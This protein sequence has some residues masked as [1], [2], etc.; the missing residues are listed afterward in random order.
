MM[1]NNLLTVVSFPGDYLAEVPFWVAIV[2]GTILSFLV[3]WFGIPSVV[4][5]AQIKNLYGEPGERDS[6]VI[7]TPRLGGTMVFAG[8]VLSSVLFTGFGPLDELKY[9]IT[10]MLVLFFIG[11]KDDVVSLAPHKKA[12]G[13][14]IAALIVVVAADLR[15][16]SF[17]GLFGINEIPWLP[18]VLLTIMGIMVVI[19][20]FNF[21]DGIDGLASGIGIVGS[22]TMGL[23]FI[24]LGDISYAV[25]AFSLAGALLAFFWYNTHSERH[26]SFL[27]DTGSMIIGFL[28]SLFVLRYLELVN[29]Q[30]GF[31][32]VLATSPSVALSVLF[33]PLF[34][35]VRICIVRLSKGKSIFKAD[36]N[37]IHH[38]VL[39]LTGSHLKSTYS[40]L[41]VNLLIVMVA[42]L[43]WS[44]SNWVLVPSIIVF[45][46]V[47]ILYV[48]LRVK[49]NNNGK[50]C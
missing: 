1:Y 6:H 4:R 49:Q 13:Q 33:I 8:V 12:I 26:K 28:L 21:I 25:M 29:E 42:S 7:P 16:T 20:S 36:S 37:H 45:A 41:G 9:I 3:A 38:K 40:I 19:N 24:Y 2:A 47:S 44:V 48:E 17:Y 30:T 43:C 39:Q 27:G 50:G 14:L 34:D 31:N 11:V 32:F 18:G 46:I 5:L 15:V 23:W 35:A 10:G 22:V